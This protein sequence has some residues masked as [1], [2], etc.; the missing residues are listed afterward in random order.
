MSDTAQIVGTII[1][2][3]CAMLSV[4]YSAKNQEAIPVLVLM[5]IAT[6]LGVILF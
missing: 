3:L 1:Y 6:L 4:I 2:I 5:A